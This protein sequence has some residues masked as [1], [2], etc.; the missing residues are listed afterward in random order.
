MT[1]L[2]RSSTDENTPSV[3]KR[4]RSG[5]NPPPPQIVPIVPDHGQRRSSRHGF[6]DDIS[7]FASGLS[8]RQFIDAPAAKLY[9]IVR[10]SAF[11]FHN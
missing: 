1:A 3:S 2:K 10:V 4:A 7:G 9:D 6:L 5:R 11:A 8:L